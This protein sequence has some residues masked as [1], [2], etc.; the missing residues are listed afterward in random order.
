[1]KE[2]PLWLDIATT[3]LW[4]QVG[5]HWDGD[6]QEVILAQDPTVIIR[7]S[8]I[9]EDGDPAAMTRNSCSEVLQKSVRN[10]QGM[11]DQY[12]NHV[13]NLEPPHTAK[14]NYKVL[15]GHLGQF[16][17]LMG[18]KMIISKFLIFF[19]FY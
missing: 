1:M 8:V 18:G 6:P 5:V 10:H 7:H 4:P 17:S 16:L 3:F 13:K 9:I 19:F 11:A 15:K 12:K 14:F 2:M